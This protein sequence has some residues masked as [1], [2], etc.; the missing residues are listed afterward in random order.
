MKANRADWAAQVP[1]NGISDKPAVFDGPNGNITIDDV[2]GL[3]AALASKQNTTG[4]ARV[5]YTG[6]YAD[7]VGKPDFGSAAFANVTDFVMAP[8]ARTL[9]V[10]EVAFVSGQQEYTVTFTRTMDA[11]PK[12]RTQ[13]FMADDNGQLFFA[14]IPKDTLTTTGFKFVLS[15]VPTLSTGSLEYE[16]VVQSQP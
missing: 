7:L 6:N 10:G 4:L 15:G 2:D 1:W 14:V 9:Q 16:A 12:V 5:A 13:V 3:R 11:V 8:T